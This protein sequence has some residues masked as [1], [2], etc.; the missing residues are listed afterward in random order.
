MD[1]NTQLIV[2]ILFFS[3]AS[4]DYAIDQ[5]IVCWRLKEYTEQY[6]KITIYSYCFIYVL[7]SDFIGL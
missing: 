2:N 1:I 3:I 6:N 5:D 4:F 7:V